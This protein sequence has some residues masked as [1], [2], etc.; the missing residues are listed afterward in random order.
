VLIEIR[1]AYY[2]ID[3]YQGVLFGP[4]TIFMLIKMP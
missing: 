1:I 3:I 2:K 4:K